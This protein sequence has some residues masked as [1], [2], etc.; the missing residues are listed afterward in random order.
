MKRRLLILLAGAVLL[1]AVALAARADAQSLPAGFVADLVV[2]EK[3]A[4]RLHLMREGRIAKTYAVVL[5]GNPIG[6]KQQEGDQRTPEGR[7]VLDWRNPK[8]QFTLALHVSYPNGA[9]R[10]AAR[11]RGVSPGGDIM[12]HG[13]P[14]WLGGADSAA[15]LPGDWTL[16]CIALSNADMREI[17]N[18]VRDGTP[19]EIRP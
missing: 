3:A 11:S 12:V 7:Y 9:D 13:Q 18:H 10:A 17:W 5:G 14:R 2:V 19:I 8:S 15:A 16:G 1:A 4:R 6:H